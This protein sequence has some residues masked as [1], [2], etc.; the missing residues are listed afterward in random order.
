MKAVRPTLLVELFVSLSPSLPPLPSFVKPL[1]QPQDRVHKL[2]R[3][4]PHTGLWQVLPSGG[5]HFFLAWGGVEGG[6]R[7]KNI[8]T[9]Q[10]VTSQPP[11]E[12]ECVLSLAQTPALSFCRSRAAGLRAGCSTH[13]CP[14]LTTLP[15]Q[16]KCNISLG[17]GESSAQPSSGTNIWLA[18]P[19]GQGAGLEV[20]CPESQWSCSWANALKSVYLDRH[21]RKSN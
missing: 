6:S 21:R 4:E 7:P 11:E 17:S 5:I 3:E 19:G 20:F 10:M 2:G 13:E 16:H 18:Q 8:Q 9:P 1:S 15:E 14:R 12:E